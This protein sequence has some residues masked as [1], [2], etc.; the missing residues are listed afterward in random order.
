MGIDIGDLSTVLLCSVLLKKRT[1]YSWVGAD[2]VMVTRQTWFW[3]TRVVD[4]QFK[5]PTQ[6]SGQ[7]KSRRHIAAEAVLLRQITA[8]TLDVYVANSPKKVI[9]VKLRSPKEE[10]DG[11]TGFPIEWLA[12][13]EEKGDELAD[14]FIGLQPSSVRSRQDLVDRLRITLQP[15]MTPSLAGQSGI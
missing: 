10:K 3:R 11:S 1:T 6:C 7:V 13:I 9:T 2:D 14:I 8:F 4:L 5:D 15:R 12:M